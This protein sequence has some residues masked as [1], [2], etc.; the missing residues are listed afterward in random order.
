MSQD[1]C[2]PSVEHLEKMLFPEWIS[3]V[4][5]LLRDHDQRLVSAEA[6]IERL[7]EHLMSHIH[8]M[9]GFVNILKIESPTQEAT[10]PECE[11]GKSMT[12]KIKDHKSIH[13]CGECGVEVN[14]ILIDGKMVPI[15][16]TEP[17]KL[18]T[19]IKQEWDKASKDADDCF[20]RT[21][22]AAVKEVER[23]IA[24]WAKDCDD[25]RITNICNS[26][27]SELRRELL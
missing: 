20:N 5:K 22:E 3:A 27:K 21:A 11:H 10:K 17:R 25:L 9:D 23:V 26:L 12:V 6:E 14:P 1:Q 24:K 16:T 13:Y 19:I 7:G 4:C 2:K 15:P 8:T 18:A